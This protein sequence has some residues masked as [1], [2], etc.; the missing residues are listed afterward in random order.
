MGWPVWDLNK[1]SEPGDLKDYLGFVPILGIVLWTR[2]KLVVRVTGDLVSASSG[3]SPIQAEMGIA[4]KFLQ[5]NVSSHGRLQEF[6]WEWKGVHNPQWG[7]KQECNRTESLLC[8]P[9]A[10][11]IACEKIPD[12][13]YGKKKSQVQN[14]GPSHTCSCW[15]QIQKDPLLSPLKDFQ[16][17]EQQ[18]LVGLAQSI[19]IFLSSTVY[20]GIK[21]RLGCWEY[22][23][24]L[25]LRRSMEEG[26]EIGFPDPSSLPGM[27]PKRS[28]LIC[29]RAEFLLII[30][31]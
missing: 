19:C 26:Q 5:Y 12:Y 11:Q 3:V 31:F 9:F 13:T 10:P 28:G 16:A 17:S 21:S 30:F 6:P 25:A 8:S 23:A 14:A 15:L 20:C 7:W 29:V 24:A 1:T 2:N 27:M 4:Q 18:I 22:S